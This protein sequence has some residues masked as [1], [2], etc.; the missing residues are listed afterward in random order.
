[1]S[2]EGVV[3]KAAGRRPGQVTMFKVKSRDWLD[4]LKAKCGDDTHMFEMLA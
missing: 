2:L 4:R 3:C 1:M